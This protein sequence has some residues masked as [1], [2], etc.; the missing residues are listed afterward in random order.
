MIRVKTTS[1]F[2]ATLAKSF[3][4]RRTLDCYGPYR[5]GVYYIYRK[6]RL[7]IRGMLSKFHQPWQ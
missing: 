6:D 7:P 5:R 4:F 2:A 3:L 1:T